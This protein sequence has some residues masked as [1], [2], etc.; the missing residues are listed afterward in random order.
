MFKKM[1]S[2]SVIASLALVSA[3]CSGGAGKDDTG[4]KPGNTVEPPKPKPALRALNQY[5]RYE[6]N[7]DPVAKA[8]ETATGYK[9]TYDLL[10]AENPDEKLNLL[11]GSKE[12][13]DF[14][15]LVPA[16]YYKLATSGALEPLDDLLAKYAPTLKSITTDA[17]WESAKING[18]IYGI[19]EVGAGKS[20][21]TQL[22]VRQDWMDELQLKV[23]TTMD[24]FYQ[25]LKTIKEKKNVIPLTGRG[26]LYAELTT[27]FGVATNWKDVNGTLVHRVE[28]PALKEYI[29]FM[30]KLYKEGLIDSEWP[31]NTDSKVIEKFTSGKAAMF[32]I[33]WWGA[34]T[35]IPAL[36]KNTP[37]AK[38]TLVPFLKNAQGKQG[39][40]ASGGTSWYTV[41]P[42]QA[43]N[44]EEAMKYLELK[45]QPDTFKLL[46]IGK[47]GE[48]FSVKDGKYYPIQPKFQDERNNSNH[49]MNGQN[50]KVYPDYWQARVRKDA[51]TQNYFETIQANAK[52]IEVLDPLTYAPPIDEISRN[53]QKLNKL[54]DDSIVQFIA[55]T[56]SLD[57]FAKFVARW[58]A[59]GG[60]E[61][62][63]GANNWYKASKKK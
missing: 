27:L 62:T 58:K 20:V 28:D 52:G 17:S 49:F 19:P 10:P 36:E 25:V 21:G 6:P 55:G 5:A 50:E 57:N 44:K 11:M 8:L 41:I 22:A 29:A 15:K 59:E 37:N 48:H 56:E 33:S 63:K 35:A 61:M 24:E 7:Q 23:P 40:L 13:Y 39:A 34:V 14:M 30:A 2:I 60:D 53:T 46:T 26:G 1:L 54:V 16:Q 9:V 18:K 38:V 45:V 43:K 3:A 42:K 51:L 32:S 12:E 31:V 47:E 4:T